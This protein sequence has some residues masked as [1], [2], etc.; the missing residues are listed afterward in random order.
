M[1]VAAARPQATPTG[2]LLAENTSPA[3]GW[4]NEGEWATRH[5]L[6]KNKTG[7]ASVF[8]GAQGVA[9]ADGFE[10]EVADGPLEID[11]E[12]GEQL[13]GLASPAQTIHV[14]SQGR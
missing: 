12:A 9:A 4:G 7:T 14:L 5:Y 11:L 8:L 10:W 6:L 13:Y 2:A 1:P 3:T